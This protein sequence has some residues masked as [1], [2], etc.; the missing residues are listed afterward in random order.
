MAHSV[1]GLLLP[2]APSAADEALTDPAIDALADFFSA[3][4]T[5]WLGNAWK[6]CAPSEPVVRTVSKWDPEETDFADRDLPLLCIWRDGNARPQ[7][8]TDDHQ[9]IGSI[10]HVV[11][12]PPPAT[13]RKQAQRHAF[14][15]AFDKGV[16][17]AVLHERDPAYRRTEDT[18]AAS[19]AYGSDVLAIAGIDDWRLQ[20][21][22]RVPIEIKIEGATTRRY[23]GYLATLAL[24]ESS[25][26]DPSAFGVSP[27][28][29]HGDL[30]DGQTPTL[31]RQSFRVPKTGS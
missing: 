22:R 18:D 21:T 9:E 4:L 7:R 28:V 27:T 19:V 30:T 31:V 5:A 12:V 8:L 17:L 1:G 29:I 14:F 6:R 13:Q 20:N 24:R 23:P 10:V 16:S 25:T 3:V 2:A 11:W 15:N 26:T